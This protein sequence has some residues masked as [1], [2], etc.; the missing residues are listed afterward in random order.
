MK[1]LRLDEEN[2]KRKRIVADLSP[3]QGQD[4]IG[5]KALKPARHGQMVDHA[6]GK[7]STCLPRAAGR[8]IAAGLAAR[9]SVTALSRHAALRRA[10][11]LRAGFLTAM[12]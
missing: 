6:R 4:V 5:R 10:L 2:G 8:A 11:L 12:R 3:R 7:H 9:R 1:R